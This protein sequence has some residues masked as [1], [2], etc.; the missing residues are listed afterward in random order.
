ME[1]HKKPGRKLLPAA[2]DAD[3]SLS[4]RQIWAQREALALKD[5]PTLS[6]VTSRLRERQ[7]AA[8]E[9]VE[10]QMDSSQGSFCF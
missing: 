6:P 7:P 3:D 8:E 4:V 2:N 5:A 1:E 10:Q 9:A